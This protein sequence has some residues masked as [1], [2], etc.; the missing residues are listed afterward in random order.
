MPKCYR[1]LRWGNVCA[2]VTS[3]TVTVW[4]AERR[5]KV[6]DGTE[7][8]SQCAGMDR[9]HLNRPVLKSSTLAQAVRQCCEDSLG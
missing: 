5:G 2:I 8:M 4:L 6:V 9:L 7:E 3:F 1:F